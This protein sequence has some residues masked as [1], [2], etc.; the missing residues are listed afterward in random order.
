MQLQVTHNYVQTNIKLQYI[1][2]LI[3]YYE[4]FIIEI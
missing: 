3:S 2:K 1:N 4:W